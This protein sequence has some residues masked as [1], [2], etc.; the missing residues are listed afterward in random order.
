MTNTGISEPIHPT[1][2]MRVM[3]NGEINNIN[4]LR[5]YLAQ[6]SAFGISSMGFG[7]DLA[8]VLGHY[9]IP[10]YFRCMCHFNCLKESPRIGT[11]RC[12]S[13]E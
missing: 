7:M 3:H 8:D 6:K 11:M 9:G 4:S 2:D 1:S 10:Q 13:A 5:I 12:F